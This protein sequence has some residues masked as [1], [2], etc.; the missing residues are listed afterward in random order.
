MTLAGRH[1]AALALAVMV[2]TVLGGCATPAA[3]APPEV[4]APSTTRLDAEWNGMAYLG[5][6]GC[7]VPCEPTPDVFTYEIEPNATLRSIHLE[8][9][10]AQSTPLTL[11]LACLDQRTC[12]FQDEVTQA[13]P[14]TVDLA[15]LEVS[16]RI[17]L[18]IMQP[19]FEAAATSSG[20]TA[21]FQATLGIDVAP[22]PAYAYVAE[23]RAASTEQFFGPAQADGGINAG[24]R[25]EA[26]EGAV[27]SATVTVRRIPPPDPA[28]EVPDVPG[29]SVKVRVACDTFSVDCRDAEE[30]SATG[31]LPF[32]GNLT[33][34]HWPRDAT[35]IVRVE[36][37]GATPMDLADSRMGQSY[38]VAMTWQV[39]VR[40]ELGPD[41]QPVEGATDGSS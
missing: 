33:F 26:G 34:A 17:Q 38:E 31:P 32:T 19:T 27:Q 23:E 2:C 22:W 15:G 5:G 14:I 24:W 10:S 8:V 28:P 3:T 39:L 12:G 30:A 40:T 13:P 4:L 1:G 7:G 11:Q 20:A 6:W 9:T 36:T 29:G 25:V 21:H 35:F 18:G 16:G 37:T 41:G